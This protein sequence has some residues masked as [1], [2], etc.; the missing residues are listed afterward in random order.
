[1]A[2]QHAARN[3]RERGFRSEKKEKWKHGRANAR[4]GRVD[5][6]FSRSE[7]M[8]HQTRH[9]PSCTRRSIRAPSAH[10]VRASR[11]RLRNRRPRHDPRSQDEMEKRCCA[12]PSAPRASAAAFACC[13]RPAPEADPLSR[14]RVTR[15]Y[16]RHRLLVRSTVRSTS[17]A[18]P[19]RNAHRPGHRRSTL[20]RLLSVSYA[21]D[22]T[23]RRASLWRVTGAARTPS[24]GNSRARSNA[25]R[26]RV[27][28]HARNA[29][30][31]EAARHR[32]FPPACAAMQCVACRPCRPAMH[33]PRPA[34]IENRCA[35]RAR[36]RSFDGLAFFYVEW[37]DALDARDAHDARR[38]RREITVVAFRKGRRGLRR[39]I[40]LRGR[41]PVLRA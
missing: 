21:P 34:A 13:A 14:C 4:R 35:W 5:R 33:R 2:R 6:A 22:R 10:S 1:M 37:N 26:R 31:Q 40:L 39:R 19:D 20:V 32:A 24:N 9:R 17:A 30:A 18:R 29:D 27:L 38:F 15:A 11:V 8:H 28:L 41:R 25:A 7:V 3:L 36:P 23:A 16:R 12:H